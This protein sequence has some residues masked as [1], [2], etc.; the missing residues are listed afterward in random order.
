MGSSEWKLTKLNNGI[1]VFRYGY[2]EEVEKEKANKGIF[3]KLLSQ[4]KQSGI[5]FKRL[6]VLKIQFDK[7]IKNKV[8][9]AAA[10][11]MII[12]LFMDLFY[13][14]IFLWGVISV[15]LM[16]FNDTKSI[17]KAIAYILGNKKSRHQ[18]SKL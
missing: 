3:G 9:I 10:F 12:Y 4:I 5:C 8:L 7:N 14:L 15:L 2:Q 13:R 17:N 16:L 18:R 1:R 6:E 11:L